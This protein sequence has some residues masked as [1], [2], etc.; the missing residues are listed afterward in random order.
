MKWKTICLST[1]LSLCFASL[2][3][4]AIPIT[5]VKA[6]MLTDGSS[7]NTQAQELVQRANLLYKTGKIQ[8]ALDMYNEAIQLDP[9]YIDAYSFRSDLLA[10]IGQLDYSVTDLQKIAEIYRSRGQLELAIDIEEF[11]GELQ[12]SRRESEL[13]IRDIQQNDS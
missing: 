13:E 7:S 4:S 5:V 11:I 2:I 8:E 10:A 6:Q 9:N 3:Y 12:Q 1:L